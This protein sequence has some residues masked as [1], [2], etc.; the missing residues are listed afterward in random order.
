MSA[1]FPYP[2]K[3]TRERFEAI[4]GARRGAD[5]ISLAVGVSRTGVF[6]WFEKGF[7]EYAHAILEW[8]ENVPQEYWPERALVAKTLAPGQKLKDIHGERACR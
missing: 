6:L 7:P 4:L 2:A 1:Q 8:L 5:R 3:E